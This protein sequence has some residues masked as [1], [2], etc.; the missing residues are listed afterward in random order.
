MPSPV[1]FAHVVFQT[2]DIP[3]LRDWWC[4][5]LEAHVVFEGGPVSFI[6]YDDEHHRVA[7]ANLDGSYEDKDPRR[8]GVFHVAFTYASLGDLLGNYERLEQQGIVPWWTVNHGPTTSMYYRDPDGNDVEL[9]IDNFATAEE[10][11]AW[12]LSP[13]FAANPI[14]VEFDADEM[15]ARYRAGESAAVLT[16]R[17]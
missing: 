12:M 7:F 9:Q 10:A 15:L 14:G 1:K 13:A 2:D 4:T 17:P 8:K 16:T 5:V 3:T 11:T 6:T